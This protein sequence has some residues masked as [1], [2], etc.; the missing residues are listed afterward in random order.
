MS[1]L[2]SEV[3]VG[4]L[5]DALHALTIPGYTVVMLFWLRLEPMWVLGAWVE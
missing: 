4:Q 2:L 3:P 5:H 1:H